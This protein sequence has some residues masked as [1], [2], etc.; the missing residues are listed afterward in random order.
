MLVVAL[1]LVG[2]PAAA[3][4]VEDWAGISQAQAIAKARASV[5]AQ[6]EA[7]KSYDV[8]IGKLMNAARV[9]HYVETVR[10]STSRTRCNGKQ[11]WKVV[12]PNSSPR[13]GYPNQFGWAHVSAM[14]VS[15][16]EGAGTANVCKKAS[17]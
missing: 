17:H 4:A 8:P 2:S 15:K 10:P 3:R 13:I 1:L 6:I 11:V 9:V 7:A 5:E 12:W 16:S 14:V